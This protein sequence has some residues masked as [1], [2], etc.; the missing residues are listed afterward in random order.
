MKR[1]SFSVQIIPLFI[2]II[3]D[4]QNHMGMSILL[5]IER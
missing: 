4:N 2:L 1:T 5:I 3:I